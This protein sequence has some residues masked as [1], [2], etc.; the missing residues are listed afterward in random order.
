MS[1][2]FQGFSAITAFREV[3]KKSQEANM[4]MLQYG[5]LTCVIFKMFK[6]FI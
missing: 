1:F 3:R 5:T 2:C 6:L 4:S